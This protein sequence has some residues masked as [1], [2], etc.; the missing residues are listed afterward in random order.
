MRK[1]N[2]S[3][4]EAWMLECKRTLSIE[5][6]ILD[7]RK[8]QSDAGASEPQRLRRPGSADSTVNTEQVRNQQPDLILFDTPGVINSHP[9]V[10]RI[11]ASLF[12]FLA[13]G[14]HGV[15]PVTFS[16]PVGSTVCLGGLLY[17][18][19]TSGR[20]MFLT[21]FVPPKIGLHLTK[22]DRAAELFEMHYRGDRVRDS[23]DRDGG[24]CSHDG[25]T[26]LKP[27]LPRTVLE[28]EAHIPFSDGEVFKSPQ[29]HL[30]VLHHSSRARTITVEGA[31][32]T[33]V[34]RDIAIPGVGWI[35]V[36]GVGQAQF[37]VRCMRPFVAFDRPPLL[38]KFDRRTVRS[39]FGTA[40]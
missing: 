3:F 15:N 1:Q 20:P 22:Q 5:G 24:G 16:L 17:I 29:S 27:C 9:V 35:G 26:I 11:P 40:V 19:A 10:G 33:S 39:F 28:S 23:F 25:Q 31:G 14:K 8:Q 12:P 37:E 36:T 18:T 4:D 13:F 32:W 30:S 21:F 7:T 6:G 34:G 2:I 38:P